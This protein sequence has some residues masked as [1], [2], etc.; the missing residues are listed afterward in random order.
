MILS[1]EAFIQINCENLLKMLVSYDTV[2]GNLL[3][4]LKYSLANREP[5][6]MK[7]MKATW[8][9]LQSLALLLYIKL[10]KFKIMKRKLLVAFEARAK[11]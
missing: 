3:R 7:S 6:I 2:I 9:P 5:Q 1:F 11:K 10:F 4:H 8:Q